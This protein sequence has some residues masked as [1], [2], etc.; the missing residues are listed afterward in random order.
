MGSNLPK[1]HERVKV[2]PCLNLKVP[3]K[4]NKT[5]IYRVPSDLESQG[6]SGNWKMVR[7]SQEKCKIIGKSQGNLQIFDKS[8]GKCEKN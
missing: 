4:V 6:E 5:S 3:R 8:R 7:E 2:V 1:A